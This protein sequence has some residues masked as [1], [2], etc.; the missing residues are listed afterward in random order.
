M[1]DQRRLA[2]AFNI[3]IEHI[4][5]DPDQPRKTIDPV[6]VQQLAASI[7]QHGILQSISVRFDPGEQTYY[8]IAGERRYLAA[9]EA[10]LTE[11]P[12]WVQR[13]EERQVLVHQIV[14]NWQRAELHPFDLADALT[15]LRDNNDYSQAD[16]ARLTGK[17]ESEISRLL[18]L[19]KLDPDV[20]KEARAE[21][22]GEITRRHLIA[23]ATLNP[24]AQ[25]QVYRTIKEKGFNALETEKLVRDTRIKAVPTDRRGAHQAER[26]RFKTENAMVLIQFRRGKV[27]Q[28]DILAALDEARQQAA[29]RQE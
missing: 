5:P 15:R 27:I 19:L 26:I 20:Q 22:S 29:Q 25:Q 24:A 10:S 3:K 23:V 6:G 2:G 7:R 14:E 18:S 1:Q 11:I 21:Q 16:L 8:I 28:A 13:P 9:K 4:R 17:P 12:C